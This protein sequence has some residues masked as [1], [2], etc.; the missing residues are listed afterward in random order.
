MASDYERE[1][2]GPR[3]TDAPGDGEALAEVRDDISAIEGGDMSRVAPWSTADEALEFLRASERRLLDR[4]A[5]KERRRNRSSLSSLLDLQSSAS[6][7]NL[8]D[9]LGLP[10]RE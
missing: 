6:V 4:I 1:I 10:P 7:D 8:R 9:R 2:H 5:T 3:V